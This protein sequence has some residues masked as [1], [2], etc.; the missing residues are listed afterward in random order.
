VR[1]HHPGTLRGV[2][3]PPRFG[4]DWTTPAPPYVPGSEQLRPIRGLRV[5][6]GIILAVAGHLVTIGAAVVADRMVSGPGWL[7]VWALGQLALLV[8]AV[9]AGIVLLVR[10]DRGVGLGVFLG[11]AGGLL[12]TPLIALAVTLLLAQQT[13]GQPR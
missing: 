3:T 13:I 6:L 10:G 9:T 4:D 12:M 1:R 11:W 2:T 7:V 5:G 8:V